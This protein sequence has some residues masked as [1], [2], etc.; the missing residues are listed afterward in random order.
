MP[1]AELED[2]E[3]DWYDHSD[4]SDAPD[5]EWVPCPECGE[6]VSLIT[7]KCRECGY[8]LTTA[9]QARTRDGGLKPLWIRLT[10]VVVII[11]LLAGFL[12]EIAKRLF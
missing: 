6:A 7:G 10:V 9:D 11:A 1:I 5:D 12:V 3:E 2:D 8:W 4:D